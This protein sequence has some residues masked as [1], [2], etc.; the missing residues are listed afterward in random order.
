MSTANNQVPA[1]LWEALQSSSSRQRPISKLL[2][3]FENGISD[4]TNKDEGPSNRYDILCPRSGCG[5]IILK[6]KVAKLVD[7]EDSPQIDPSNLPLHPVLTEITA[8][9]ESSS[10]WWL[11]TPSPMQFENVGFSK[12]TEAM[13][14]PSGKKLKL[15]A[16]A[17]CDLGPLGWS[18]E[19]GTEFW[20]ASTRVGYRADQ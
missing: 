3:S 1:G 2:K 5:S 20:L 6:N 13:L 17:E 8:D 12:T 4:I 15:L 10:K 9:S 7:R 16:C 11:I 19:G 14:G 18:E